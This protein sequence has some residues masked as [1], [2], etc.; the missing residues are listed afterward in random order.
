MIDSRRGKAR[1]KARAEADLKSRLGEPGVVKP[2]LFGASS[3]Y[4]VAL[5]G[6]KSLFGLLEAIIPCKR[7][8]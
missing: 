6:I 7:F 1:A 5:L 8:F 3:P 4:T 2:D